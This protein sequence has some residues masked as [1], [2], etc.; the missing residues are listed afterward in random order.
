MADKLD[1]FATWQNGA[2]F[3]FAVVVA[4]W[5]GE[6]MSAAEVSAIFIVAFALARLLTALLQAVWKRFVIGSR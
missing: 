1:W 3:L 5:L 4:A 2:S 6:D